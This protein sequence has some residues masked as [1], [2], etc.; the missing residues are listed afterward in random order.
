[1]MIRGRLATLS[2]R[3]K[4]AEPRRI[5]NLAA[6]LKDRGTTFADVCVE[7]ISTKGCKFTP[8]GAAELGDGV[9]LKLPGLEPIPGRIAWIDGS[10]G[11]CAFG[12][13]LHESDLDLLRSQAFSRPKGRVTSFGRRT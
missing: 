6:R 7:D 2:I 8:I 3:A 11:G 10:D 9:W 5:V 1:M 4:R 12:R 13:E